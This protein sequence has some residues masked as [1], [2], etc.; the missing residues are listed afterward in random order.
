[1]LNSRSKTLLAASL[2]V[3]LAAAGFALAGAGKDYADTS[4]RWMKAFNAGDAAGIAAL[5]TE[6]GTA[7]PPN[8]PAV[9]G[10]A[11]IEAYLAEDIAGSPAGGKLT[12]KVTDQ[13]HSG[14]LGYARGTWSM[15]DA[16][17]AVVDRGKWVEVRKRVKGNWYIHVDT[18]NSDL[19]RSTE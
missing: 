13:D 4:E 5:Y 12:V 1:M 14:D 18:W 10:R 7:M 11:A 17:G 15:T 8:A 6:D 9:K 19:P 2:A 16:S 3:A